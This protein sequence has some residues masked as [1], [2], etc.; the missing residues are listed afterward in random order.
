MAKSPGNNFIFVERPYLQSSNPLPTK[1][2]L[3]LKATK[4]FHGPVSKS[5][6]ALLKVKALV[7]FISAC[8]NVA[9]RFEWTLCFTEIQENDCVLFDVSGMHCISSFFFTS[10]TNK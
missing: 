1:C 3:S 2:S 8:V 9:I 7:W 4:I 5:N 6:T 10:A